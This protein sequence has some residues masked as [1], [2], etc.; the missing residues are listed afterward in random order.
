MDDFKTRTKGPMKCNTHASSKND[1]AYSS[2]MKEQ[3]GIFCHSTVTGHGETVG[4]F[5]G[6]VSH[7]LNQA[8]KELCFLQL[9]SYSRVKKKKRRK[10]EEKRDRKK[11]KKGKENKR[12]RRRRRQE[13][14]THLGLCSI[15]QR[16]K[17]K[18]RKKEEV[19]R[20]IKKE[21]RKGNNN[22]KGKHRS[23]LNF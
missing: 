5:V 4:A 23:D 19:R 13:E 16:R 14:K 17:K 9:I 6:E 7:G 11:I 10:G 2:E 21:K 3:A 22:L 15:Q 1:E 8:M 12:R 18:R 20:K